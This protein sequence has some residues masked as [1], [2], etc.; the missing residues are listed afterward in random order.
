MPKNQANRGKSSEAQVQAQLEAA[1][2]QAVTAFYRLPDARAGSRLPTLADF[3]V[4]HQ[5]RTLLL[6]VK[7]VDHAFRL[8]HDNFKVDQ[9]ARMY[10]F[11]LAGA[12]PWVLIHHTPQNAWRLLSLAAFRSR[13][14]GG[15][16]NFKDVQETTLQ[17]ALKAL[18]NA[19]PE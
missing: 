15:S 16:W 1:S 13:A 8:P 6:E 3:L 5:G 7:E 9:V 12:E 19:N 14:D 11:S 2:S 4:L 10:R 17:Q 18:L